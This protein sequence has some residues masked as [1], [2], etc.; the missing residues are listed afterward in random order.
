MVSHETLVS[1]AEVLKGDFQPSTE[2]WLMSSKR[3]VVFQWTGAT[4]DDFGLH[5]NGFKLAP[6]LK[7]L[8][9]N[10]KQV[11]DICQASLSSCS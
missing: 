1:K 6:R 10:A 4:E 9:L 5:L 8:T 11:D 2:E 7:S 3:E